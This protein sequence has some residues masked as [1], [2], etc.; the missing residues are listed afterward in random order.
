MILLVLSDLTTG[1]F[2][3]LIEL[4]SRKIEADV[5]K[6]IHEALRIHAPH[7]LPTIQKVIG[8]A[9]ID[10]PDG[11]SGSSIHATLTTTLPW[12]EGEP[13][14]RALEAIEREHGYQALFAGR[15]INWLVLCWRQFS[16]PR[17]LPP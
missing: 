5:V 8:S 6:G 11:S 13:V 12:D 2:V 10:G 14:L 17:Q 16:E 7:L 1:S 15:Q 4:V 3:Y 9:W